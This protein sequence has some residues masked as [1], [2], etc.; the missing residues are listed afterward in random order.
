MIGGDTDSIMSIIWIPLFLFL[1][2]YGQKIQLFMITRNI[3]KSLTK[4]EKM[5]TDARNKVL[6]TLLEYGGEKKY[7]E[8]NNF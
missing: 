2:L 6:E 8:E 1:M 4:L 3:G 5:K 7:V